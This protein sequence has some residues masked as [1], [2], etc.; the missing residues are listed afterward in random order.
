M[1]ASFGKASV[2]GFDSGYG[3]QEQDAN[4]ALLELDKGLLLIFM[5][6]NFV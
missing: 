6:S 1:F 2:V 5:A 4:S 3:D